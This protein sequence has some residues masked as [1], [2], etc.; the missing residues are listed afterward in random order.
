MQTKTIT[1]RYLGMREYEE[2]F[3]AMREFT[4]KRSS[5]TPDEVWLLEH[6]HVFTQGKA[7][8]KEHIL[9][10]GNVPIVQTDRGG[11]VT[12]HGPGQLIIYPLIDLR[13]NNLG[14]KKFVNLLEKTVVDTLAD[15]GISAHAR[16]DAPG[17][18]ITDSGAKICS[19]GLRIKKGCSYHGLALNITTDLSYFKRIN[20]CGYKN[21]QLVNLTELVAS[22]NTIKSEELNDKVIAHL[23]KNFGY[24]QMTQTT[25]LD[26]EI[27][28]P[29]PSSLRKPPWIRSKL[30]A[31]NETAKTK[32]ILHA[33]HLATVCDEAAC[34]NR[35]ECFGRG[36]ATFMIMGSTCTRNC[37]FCNVTCGRPQPL[38]SNEPQLLAQTVA[39]LQLKYVVITSV[40]R[41]DL[42]DHGAMHFA[43]CIKAL[44]ETNPALR[45][46][47]LVPDFCICQDAA[48]KIIAQNP[49][50]VFGHNI[51]TVP[52][53][54]SAITKSSD[55]KLSLQLLQKH[56]QLMPHIPT[57]SGIMVGLGETDEEICEVFS[58]LRTHDVDM[59]TVGQYLQPNLKNIQVTRYVT[60]EQFQKFAKIARQMGFKYVASGPMVRS[61]YY[62]E[63]QTF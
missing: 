33:S 24:T 25:S 18:Y 43:T 5:E 34:P 38:D 27:A 41:D 22:K 32:K 54:Y 6:P 63:Q 53:L 17:I 39:A 8:K 30:S 28:K 31:T 61:S 59:L 21:L 4:E 45:I 40:C 7:G 57:K 48:L 50:D 42:N 37:R 49:A 58:D 19:L 36:T 16:D 3:A 1:V 23:A 46:E 56:K 52:R 14:V 20:P 10:S 29:P 13:R 12:Y 26:T 35:G 55:Y 9:N 2:T 15:Y 47:V 62:A 11:Q 51:E 60:P 44:R